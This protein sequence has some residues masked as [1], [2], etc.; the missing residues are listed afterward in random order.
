[1]SGIRGGFATSRTLLLGVALVAAVL[2]PHPGLLSPAR[3]EDRERVPVPK[4][5]LLLDDGDSVAIRWKE[6][7]ETVRL[8]GIDAPETLHLEHD[9]PYPQPFGGDA[10]AFLAGCVAGA[11]RVELVRSG[12]KDP[13]GRTLGYLWLDGRNYSVTALEARLAVET[14]GHFGDNGFPEEAAACLAA[15]KAAGPVA[16]EEPHLY[17]RRMKAVSKW[18]KE[19]GLYPRG[20]DAAPEKNAPE[21]S[22]G[23]KPGGEKR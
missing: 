1:M 9:I 17:R 10:A 4:A 3:A 19:R 22:P 13:Y 7:I 20:P 15:A 6:G 23:E 5:A 14:V 2:W 16:F 18:M 11:T 21:K 8:L 12:Q